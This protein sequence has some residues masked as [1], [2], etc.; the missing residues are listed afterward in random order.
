MLENG[1]VPEDWRKDNVTPVL[2]KSKERTGKY[3]PVSLT[4]ITGKVVEYLILEAT[5]KHVEYK[6]GDQGAVNMT[7]LQGLTDLIV[8]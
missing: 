3:S 7:S 1:D 6:K 4:S 2:K 8:F 5:F